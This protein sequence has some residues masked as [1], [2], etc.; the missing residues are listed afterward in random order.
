VAVL[1]V[2]ILVGHRMGSIRLQVNKL[3]LSP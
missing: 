2:A 3:A 1:L